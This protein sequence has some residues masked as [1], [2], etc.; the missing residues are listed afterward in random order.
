MSNNEESTY[1]IQS[2]CAA[3]RNLEYVAVENRTLEYQLICDKIKQFIEINCVHKI[4]QDSVD[5]SCD[6]SQS[7]KYCI[8]CEKTF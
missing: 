2:M 4:V 8:H 7:I 1:A 5:I 6:C 3:L